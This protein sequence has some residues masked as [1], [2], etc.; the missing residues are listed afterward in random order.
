MEL[1]LP[2]MKKRIG[3]SGRPPRKWRGVMEVLFWAL[4]TG[5]QWSEL[6]KC[7]PP[8]STVHDRQVEK[9]AVYSG[10]VNGEKVVINT[11]LLRI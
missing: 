6:P 9:N 8:K 4:K 10:W 3:A 5:E 1:L 7:Y 2:K 11:T